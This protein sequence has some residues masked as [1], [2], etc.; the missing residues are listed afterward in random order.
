[1]GFYPCQALS[2]SI[3]VSD[4]VLSRCFSD[5]CPPFRSTSFLC[6]I[7][8]PFRYTCL[9]EQNR[10]FPNELM[11]PA[12]KVKSGYRGHRE[13]ELP[14]NDPEFRGLHSPQRPERLFRRC[15]RKIPSKMYQVSG[16][17]FTRAENRKLS[18]ALAAVGDFPSY[19]GIFPRPLQVRIEQLRTTHKCFAKERR[20]VQISRHGNELH[21]LR[22]RRLGRASVT[23]LTTRTCRQPQCFDDDAGEPFVNS[24]KKQHLRSE[25]KQVGIGRKGKGA[26]GYA[27]GRPPATI[28]R[29]LTTGHRPRHRTTDHRP[30]TTDH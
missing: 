10:A 20:S 21:H 15:T 9:K 24:M 17:E 3:T 18:T 28:E 1:M 2:L 25:S 27:L 16:H 30:L 4:S 23:H 14:E 8:P 22:C 19:G 12:T 13:V 26:S 29:L 5:P 7:F 11:A 6:R